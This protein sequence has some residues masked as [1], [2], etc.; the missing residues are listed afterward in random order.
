MSLVLS[1]LFAFGAYVIT[2]VLCVTQFLTVAAWVPLGL[3]CAGAVLWLALSWE[4]GVGNSHLVVSFRLSPC[5]YHAFFQAEENVVV[6]VSVGVSV[7]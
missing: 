4:G 5:R 7:L 6:S 3:T 2:T 1:L